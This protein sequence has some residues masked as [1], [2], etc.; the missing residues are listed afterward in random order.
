MIKSEIPD[1][2]DRVFYISGPP[3]MV[4]SLKDIL[5]NRLNVKDDKVILENFTGY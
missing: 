3:G 5:K 4:D 1:F 2:S